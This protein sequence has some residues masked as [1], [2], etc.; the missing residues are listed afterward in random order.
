MADGKKVYGD[1]LRRHAFLILAGMIL[2]IL[3]FVAMMRRQDLK[4]RW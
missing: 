2:L 1:K 4:Y 3:C